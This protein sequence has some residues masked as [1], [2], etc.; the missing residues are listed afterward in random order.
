MRFKDI[1]PDEFYLDCVNAAYR[2]TIN[3]EDLPVDGC[4]QITKRVEAVLRT[5][6]GHADLDKRRVMGEML[7][8][9]DQWQKLEELPGDTA[10]HAEKLIT[11][12]NQAFE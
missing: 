4:D 7:R 11:K 3:L 8:R 6:H 9:F 12:I 5:R 2:Y 1:F 10:K